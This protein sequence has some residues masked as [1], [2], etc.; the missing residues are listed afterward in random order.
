MST[1]DRV[2]DT[3]ELLDLYRSQTVSLKKEIEAKDKRIAE[4]EA[5]LRFAW[6]VIG[7]W[8]IGG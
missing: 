1:N 6:Q 2:S 3:Q 4:F 5:A 8:K 7:L